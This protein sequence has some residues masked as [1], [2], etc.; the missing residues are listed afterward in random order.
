MH[1]RSVLPLPSQNVH[2]LSPRVHLLVAPL[3]DAGYGLVAGLAPLELGARDDDIGG[4]ELGVGHKGRIILLH[5]EASD[6]H[7][8]LG[9][10]DLYHLCLRLLAFAVGRDLHPH[11]VAVEGVHG[12]SLG[13]ENHLVVDHHSVSPVASAHENAR[14]LRATVGVGLISPEVH[15]KDHVG[16]GQLVEQVYHVD[17]VGRVRGPHGKCH[18]LVVESLPALLFQKLQYAFLKL[19][20]FQA[21]SRGSFFIFILHIGLYLF[22]VA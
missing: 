5:L 6:K 19:S 15:L 3:H 2:H 12:V 9:F 14:V 22:V 17:T 13:H 16:C 11:L 20:F 8:V 21:W 10:D 4:K 18:L 7:L 1:L